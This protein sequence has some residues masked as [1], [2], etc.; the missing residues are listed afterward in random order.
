MIEL[1]EAG[2]HTNEEIT[3]EVG[4]TIG[5]VEAARSGFGDTDDTMDSGP[6]DTD[7]D[8]EGDE[9]D[10]DDSEKSVMQQRADRLTAEMAEETV[11]S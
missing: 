5:M 3:D 1:I 6:E 10:E 11:L 4:A 7:S 8:D 2:R 9:T